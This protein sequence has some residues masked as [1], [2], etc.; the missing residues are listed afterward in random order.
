KENWRQWWQKHK[1]DIEADFPAKE[2]VAAEKEVASKLSQLE[3]LL[4]KPPIVAYDVKLNFADPTVRDG[5]FHSEQSVAFALSFHNIEIPPAGK[6]TLDHLLIGQTTWPV[7]LEENG[8]TIHEGVAGQK[9][10]YLKW[11]ADEPR[12]DKAIK[13]P[14]K[15]GNKEYSCPVHIELNRRDKDTPI[16][17]YW[18]C[19]YLSGRL[20]WGAG[21]C[22][23][24]IVN[25]DQQMEF[26]LTGDGGDPRDAVLGIDI[27]GDGRIDPAKEGGEQFDL[28]EPFI[29]GS[30]TYQLAEVDPYLPRVVFRELDALMLPHPLAKADVPV[31]EQKGS[32]EIAEGTTIYKNTIRFTGVVT[33][34]ME[35]DPSGNH[36]TFAV[37]DD[38]RF[39]LFLQVTAADPQNYWFQPGSDVDFLIHDPVVLFGGE[40]KEVVGKSY[41]FV[42][43]EAM[44]F[45]VGGDMERRHTLLSVKPQAAK[46]KSD[47]PVEFEGPGEENQVI[48]G[49]PRQGVQVGVNVEKEKWRIGGD[50]PRLNV[51]VRVSD[52]KKFRESGLAEKTMAHDWS[53]FA[54]EV[55]GKRYKQN[56]F[57]TVEPVQLLSPFKIVLSLD[58]EWQGGLYGQEWLAPGRHKIR[59]LFV[60]L[61]MRLPSE[62][63]EIEILPEDKKLE[64]WPYPWG[65]AVR[66]VQVSAHPA[67]PSWPV[68]SEPVIRICL[69]NQGQE[70][71]SIHERPSSFA[72]EVDGKRY[73]NNFIFHVWRRLFEP[74]DVRQFDL[75]LSK[76]KS[77]HD[78]LRKG[79]VWP[80]VGKPPPL[81]VGKHTVRVLFTEL[82]IEPEPASRQIEFEIVPATSGVRVEAEPGGATSGL[83]WGKQ[84]NGLR[85]AVE[86]VPQKKSYSLGERVGIRF[87]VQNVSAE[88]IQFISDTWRQ[89]DRAT[90]EDEDGKRQPVSTAWYSDWTAVD[91]YYLKPGEKAV[92]ESSDFGIAANNEQADDLG[93]PVGYTLVCV[94]G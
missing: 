22:R 65:E 24:E 93:Y 72:I 11:P 40:Q 62:P 43:G 89:N 81:L 51:E 8:I 1:A 25:L 48:W 38:P 59:V 70:K 10:S 44:D 47:V 56:V 7:H 88:P 76:S 58:D 37:E 34:I 55:D 68:G 5:S 31:E 80:P 28:Y 6:F 23:F 39:I 50:V 41:Y 4:A 46:S 86:F 32:S 74:G 57:T 36:D 53:A 84:V 94:P 61:G 66:G 73:E 83:V 49:K 21:G 54:V 26:R 92:V 3:R 69:R 13:I 20:P 71:W 75:K 77:F 87:H 17:S 15:Y 2:E 30:K 64:P 82:G 79:N 67:Q 33:K 19:A 45:V 9:I 63:V 52:P 18:F 35:F 78:G 60:G 91:R 85:A 27:D 12:F 42:M 16:G 14:V 29:I 90:I